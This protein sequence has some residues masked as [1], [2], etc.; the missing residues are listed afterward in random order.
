MRTY[1]QILAEAQAQKQIQASAPIRANA[2]LNSLPAEPQHE[3]EQT[4]Q[5]EAAARGAAQGASFGFSDEIQAGLGTAT[6]TILGQSTNY[7]KE[8]ADVRAREELA[9]QEWSKTHLA[10]NIAGG[11]LTTLIPGFGL[12]KGGSILKG[13]AQAAKGAALAGFGGADGGL[14]ERLKG[15]AIAGTAGALLG[16]AAGALGKAGAAA[17]DE[18]AVGVQA[19]KALGGTTDEMGAAYAKTVAGEGAKLS[20]K[21]GLAAM[22]KDLLDQEYLKP[23]QSIH[24]IKEAVSRDLESTGQSLGGFLE[25]LDGLS[26]KPIVNA[27]RVF[28]KLQKAI[29]KQAVD[30]TD[31]TVAR[32]VKQRPLSGSMLEN[33]AESEAILSA[34]APRLRSFVGQYIE[35]AIAEGRTPRLTLGQ[36]QAFR[37]SM[38]DGIYSNETSKA[39]IKA[40]RAVERVIA[41]ELEQGVALAGGKADQVAFQGLKRQFQFLSLAKQ[42]A[43]EG[44]KKVENLSRGAMVAALGGGIGGVAGSLV[45]GGNPLF[46]LAAIGGTAAALPTAASHALPLAAAARSGLSSIAGA[47]PGAVA[48]AASLAG[49]GTLQSLFTK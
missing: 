25:R 6:K 21:D 33:N 12:A 37:Q 14:E 13:A 47:V 49:R 45:S 38:A 15:G 10:S 24:Q 32:M 39:G 16:G 44:S 26:P 3:A 5:L 9:K 7:E 35:P 20:P 8:L 34:L 17:V 40:L 29:G 43:T 46:A 11:A 41:D 48:P 23:G 1:E 31:D 27:E 22:G 28:S 18:K 4:S 42:A 36:L 30:I 2:A 19:A